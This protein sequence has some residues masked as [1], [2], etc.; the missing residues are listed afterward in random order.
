MLK[1]EICL[2]IEGRSR[3]VGEL[4]AAVV[5]A[6]NREEDGPSGSRPSQII[7]EKE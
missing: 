1:E 2:E 6:Q 7:E 5:A 4:H 3:V